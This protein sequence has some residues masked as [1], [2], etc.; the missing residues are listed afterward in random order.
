MAEPVE[1]DWNQSPV[2]T[3]QLVMLYGYGTG[4]QQKFYNVN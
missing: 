4:K 2:R 1:Q 3:V